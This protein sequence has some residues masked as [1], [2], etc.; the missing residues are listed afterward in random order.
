MIQ[1]IPCCISTPWSKDERLDCHPLRYIDP[2]SVPM[3]VDTAGAWCLVSIT[4]ETLYHKLWPGRGLDKTTFGLQ[5]HSKELIGVV[6]S[7]DVEVA[8]EGQAATLPLVIVKGQG[9]TLLG[10]NWLSQIRVT[11]IRLPILVCMSCLPTI[12]KFFRKDLEVSR[13]MRQR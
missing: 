1:M 6:G 13:D 5:T 9:P 11:F 2:C 7:I 4:P 3:E 10:R 12:L 8:L